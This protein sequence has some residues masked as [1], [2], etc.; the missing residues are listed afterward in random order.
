MEEQKAPSLRF[1]EFEE[2]WNPIKLGNKT[3]KVGSGVT[4]RGGSN[5]Y[6]D[7]GYLFIRSQN[8]NQNRLLLDDV[9]Y[10]PEEIHKSMSSSV[11]YP[12][13]ILLNITGAS[14]GRSCLVTEEIEE[15]NVNQHVCI[16]RLKNTEVPK[17]YQIYLASRR[18]QKLV[19]QG[20][21]GGGR[22]GLNFS[23]IRSFKF[24]IPKEPEQQKIAS[25]LSAVD[26]KIEQLTRKKELLEEYKKGV[27][28][29]LFPKPGEQYPEFRFKDE[30][31]EDFPDWE[32]KR[33]GEIADRI[34]NKNTENKYSFVLTNSATQ[35]IVSQ[36]DYFDKDIANQNNL[37]GYYIV[38][39]DDFVYNPRISV[40]APVG[41]I[42][43]N[44][45]ET[46][47]MSP[48]YS[49]FRFSEDSIDYFESFFE[50]TVWHKHMHSVANYGARHDRMNITVDDFM[51]LPIPFPNEKE[52]D[53]IT[54]FLNELNLKIH[55]SKKELG[56]MLVFKKGLLQQMFV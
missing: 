20:Q 5:V 1:P 7:S 41:P 8:V 34:T 17:F 49:V 14:I 11:V 2:E 12:K 16:I 40:H 35:G 26:K 28:Q 38:E 56:S 18:G 30:N 29:K 9:A 15:A 22:E 31:G 47:V 51:S 37:D 53:K 21:A 10:I 44:T 39:Q 24:K 32:V 55:S 33:L 52:R 48:L 27:M 46:G 45:L 36:T 19:Y 54:Y 42:K 43:R 13:D 6:T 4:P 50:T 23:S 25:F 3:N